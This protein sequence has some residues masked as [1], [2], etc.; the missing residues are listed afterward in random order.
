MLDGAI[1]ISQLLCV[2]PIK[3]F[4]QLKT[5]IQLLSFKF[6]ISLD[7]LSAMA[8]IIVFGKPET[9]DG[10]MLPSMTRSLLTPMTLKLQDELM[11]FICEHS[12]SAPQFAVYNGSDRTRA[13]WMMSR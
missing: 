8:M 7:A 4:K 5:N 11:N 3:I 10:K 1:K 6:R 13:T 12:L 2:F 9:G